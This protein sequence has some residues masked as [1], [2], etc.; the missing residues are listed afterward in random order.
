MRKLRMM[1]TQSI[2][3][4]KRLQGNQPRQSQRQRSLDVV[5]SSMNLTR[6][7]LV[8]V[9]CKCS[10]CP[11]IDITGHD[12]PCSGSACTCAAVYQAAKRLRAA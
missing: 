10:T 3:N 8:R 2:C 6:R 1:M 11:V 4:R 9:D 12:M 7:M 5:F